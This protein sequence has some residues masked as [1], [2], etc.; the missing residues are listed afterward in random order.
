[1]QGDENGETPR[2]R[3]LP[4]YTNCG[5]AYLA[6]GMNSDGEVTGKYM[7]SDGVF[8][9]SPLQ[10]FDMGGAPF[11][12]KSAG[13]QSQYR[14][15]LV[16]AAAEAGWPDDGTVVFLALEVTPMGELGEDSVLAKTCRVCVTEFDMRIGLLAPCLDRV[17]GGCLF[18]VRLL[19]PC[20]KEGLAPIVYDLLEGLAPEGRL[21]RVV[22]VAADALKTDSR[23]ASSVLYGWRKW[24]ARSG[25][26]NTRLFEGLLPGPPRTTEEF[27][28]DPVVLLE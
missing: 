19:Y 15:D 13:V 6:I 3:N 26:A 22:F 17:S 24:L 1:M 5:L 25:I 20:R 7:M 4:W 16:V 23:E 14:Q 8:S 2:R 12:G 28:R 21:G 10:C 11:V 27:Q 18:A 9:E